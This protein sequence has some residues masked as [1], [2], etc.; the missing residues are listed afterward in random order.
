VLLTHS[1]TAA[2]EM[3]AILAGV[4]LGDE[5]NVPFASMSNPFAPIHSGGAD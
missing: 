3:S 2:L 1:C 4:A 5:V